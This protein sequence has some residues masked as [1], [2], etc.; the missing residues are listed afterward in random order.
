[1]AS[2]VGTATGPRRAHPALSRPVA[3][4]PMSRCLVRSETLDQLYLIEDRNASEPTCLLAWGMR[5]HRVPQDRPRTIPPALVEL[6]R[7]DIVIGNGDN[8]P[9]A[10]LPPREEL[11][12]GDEV[13]ADTGA[14][15][16]RIRLRAPGCE[17]RRRNAAVGLRDQ[18]RNLLERHSL[19]VGNE[20]HVAEV[21]LK[22]LERLLPLRRRGFSNEHGRQIQMRATATHHPQP[23]ISPVDELAAPA[24]AQDGRFR[25]DRQVV[26]IP[27]S[28]NGR[29][30]YYSPR[31][32]ARVFAGCDVDSAG[33]R[34]GARL[35]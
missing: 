2:R 14:L 5:G 17:T 34:S 12:F 4:T 20:L 28:T 8:H 27:G 19:T 3:G 21:A 29:V 32:S 13:A 11:R 16:H 15:A 23:G 18:R 9:R 30:E 10:L 7:R 33:R 6:E 22:Q 35:H 31:G 25:V 1:M 24:A 26:H